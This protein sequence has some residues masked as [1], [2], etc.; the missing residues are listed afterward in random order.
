MEWPRTLLRGGSG[1][2]AADSGRECATQAELETWWQIA[3]S[4]FGGCP[5]H[6]RKLERGSA[7]ARCSADSAGGTLAGEG[8]V[9][10]AAV[11]CWF[12]HAGSCASHEGFPGDC[13]EVLD[14]RTSL[15]PFAVE[16]Q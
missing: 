2:D 8:S 4:R 11:L 16:G 5:R 12:D 13:G 10:E 1:G 14:V 6:N 7:G 3:A 15:A 9:G